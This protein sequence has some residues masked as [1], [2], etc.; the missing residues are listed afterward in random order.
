M[1]RANW[2]QLRIY[3]IA[4]EQVITQLYIKYILVFYIFELQ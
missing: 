3:R 1:V 2:L 4:T